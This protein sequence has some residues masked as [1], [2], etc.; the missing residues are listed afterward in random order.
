MSLSHFPIVHIQGKFSEIICGC[1]Y[2]SLLFCLFFAFKLSASHF[3]ID[4]IMDQQ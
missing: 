2:D 1:R 3:I 4:Q